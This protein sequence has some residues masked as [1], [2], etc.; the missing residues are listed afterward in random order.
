MFDFHKEIIDIEYLR[1]Q[2]TRRTKSK[3]FINSDVREL[4]GA[5]CERVTPI[6]ITRFALKSFSLS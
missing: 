6:T 4:A 5:M 2:A 3:V 1:Q